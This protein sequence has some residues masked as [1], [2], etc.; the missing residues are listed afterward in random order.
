MNEDKQS[1]RVSIVS[2]LQGSLMNQ[3]GIQSLHF[4][5]LRGFREPIKPP[6]PKGA[7]RSGICRRS[8][9]SKLPE[10]RI[11]DMVPGPGISRSFSR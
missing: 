9:N 2:P 10:S 5:S 1:G 8:E 4:T 11:K 6:T 3:N 7:P